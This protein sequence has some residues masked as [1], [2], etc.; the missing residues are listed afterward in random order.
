MS[1]P[2]LALQGAIVAALKGNAVGVADRVYDE[3]PTAPTFPYVTVGDD[4]V[5]GDDD[6]CGDNSE[7]FVRIHGWSRAT[8]YPEVK[9]IA[10]LIRSTVKGAT[11][12]LTGFTVVVTEFQQTQFLQDPD[13][14]TRHSV[15]EFRFLITHD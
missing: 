12:A 11:F 15:T 7:V 1:D 9:A 5:I 4:Q 3:A 8:G 6:E 2:S 13:G 14:L 10:A